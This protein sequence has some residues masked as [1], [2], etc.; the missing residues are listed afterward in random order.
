MHWAFCWYTAQNIAAW[1]FGGKGV[2]FGGIVD[3]EVVCNYIHE[4]ANEHTIFNQH[5]IKG[6]I[7]RGQCRMKANTRFTV[8]YFCSRPL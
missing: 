6:N 5:Q 1:V 8:K 2:L 3:L 7:R 4:L